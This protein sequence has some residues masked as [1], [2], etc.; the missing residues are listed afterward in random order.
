MRDEA[1]RRN[2][3]GNVARR[4]AVLEI[5]ALYVTYLY[6]ILP[7][8]MRSNE[9]GG[10]FTQLYTAG[11]AGTSEGSTAEAVPGQPDHRGFGWPTF[12]PP[13]E[14]RFW[15]RDFLLLS[16]GTCGHTILLGG[17][18]ATLTLSSMEHR[19]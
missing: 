11:S 1:D 17:K 16:R 4:R 15:Q 18:Q 13:T 6:P 5:A 14:Q 3:K 12:T 7:S 2:S 10:I 19:A 9:R 8:T